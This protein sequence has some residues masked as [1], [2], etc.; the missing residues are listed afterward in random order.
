MNEMFDAVVNY[1]VSVVAVVAMGF[2]IYKIVTRYF[3]ESK[4]REKNLIDCNNNYSEVLIKLNNTISENTKVNNELSETNRLLVDKIEGKL[5][6]M[7][8]SLSIVV[9]KLGNN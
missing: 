1:G 6:K 5:D 4:E 3:D 8:N 7:D 9:D 2:F